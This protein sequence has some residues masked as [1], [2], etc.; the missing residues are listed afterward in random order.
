[1]K[2]F[3]DGS[4]MEFA[5]LLGVLIDTDT[6]DVKN[7]GKIEAH[8]QKIQGLLKDVIGMKTNQTKLDG[9]DEIGLPTE[10]IQQIVDEL[11]AVKAK[12]TTQTS[13]PSATN[14]NK[15]SKAEAK[16]VL[17]QIFHGAPPD[18]IDSLIKTA[19]DTDT[20]EIIKAFKAMTLTRIKKLEHG[21][22]RNLANEICVVRECVET[23]LHRKI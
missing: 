6:D 13:V 23:I 20:E 18:F 11:K 3:I 17:E 4:G 2:V 9:D 10:M 19:S 1:M 16:A 22:C 14:Q 21:D 5:G 7:T 8:L 15:F 12:Q